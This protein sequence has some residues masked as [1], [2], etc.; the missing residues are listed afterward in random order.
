[1]NQLFRV[2]LLLLFATVAL[3]LSNAVTAQ[4]LPFDLPVPYNTVARYDSSV[5]TPEE[6]IGHR[7]GSRHTTPSQVVAYFRA[8]ANASDRVVLEVHGQTYE[9]RPLIHA[10]ITSADNHRRLDAIRRDNLRLVEDPSGVSDEQLQNMP[11]VFY[12]GYSIHGNEATGTEAAVLFLYHLAAGRDSELDDALNNTVIL[13]DPMF[14][15]DGRDR[16]VD[17]VNRWRGAVATTDPQ[18]LEHNEPWPGGRTNHYFFDLNRDWLPAQQQES[19][20]R[21]ELF[22]QWKPQLLTDHHEMGGNSTFFFQPGVPSRT[23][24]NTPAINQQLTE[25]IGTYHAAALDSYGAL[26]YSK[27]SFDDFYYGK[28]STYPDINGSIGILFEQA[29]S[30]ALQTETNNGVLTYAFGVRNHFA[31]SLS[32]LQA[33]QDMRVALLKNQ[34]DFYRSETKF[35]DDQPIDGYVI[36]TAAAPHRAAVLLDIFRRHRIQAYVL[37]SHF[38][39]G[40]EKFEAGDAVYVPLKQTQGRLAKAILETSRTFTDSLF[41][42]VSTW[43]LPLAMDLRYAE[44]PKRKAPSVG[45]QVVPEDVRKATSGV[46]GRARYAYLIQ[47]GPYDLPAM[48]YRL[49]DKGV[50]LQLMTEPVTVQADGHRVDLDRGAVVVPV[51]QLDVPVDSVHAMVRRLADKYAIKVM[52]V[53]TGATLDGP[54]LGSGSAR[55]IARPEVAIVAGSRQSS[56]MVGEAWQLLSERLRMPVSLLDVDG[57]SSDNLS[58][59][60]VIV[61][62]GSGADGKPIAEWVRSGGTLITMGSGTGWAMDNGLA[63]LKRRPFQM[64]SVLAG[65]SYADLGD[66]RGAQSLGGSIVRGDVDNTHP[67]AYGVGTVLPLFQQGTVVYDAPEEPGAAVV[68]VSDHP[69]WS[70]YFSPLHRELLPGTMAIASFRSGR[71]SVITFAGDPNFRQFWY[72]TS[73]LFVNAVFLGSTL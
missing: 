27:Q 15:P 51:A 1:M 23:N 12:A 10:V 70:G 52:S 69:E 5:P 47:W 57:L 7:I 56:S 67:V 68:T 55:Q 9:G 59:Y 34:R 43:T 24:P 11:A 18:D 39:A 60:N 42:D 16:F 29:S 73:R 45:K 21:L 46:N 37:A 3:S 72:G 40:N 19:R 22:H 31:A 71:G 48:L 44:V 63:G 33:L 13:L 28:G 4:S 14:N 25:Q 65:V 54:F 62:A 8:V 17:W 64:D 20:G 32:S 53:E 2:V 41:Y 50:R 35:A 38:E 6:V 66:T 58:R 36:E 26:Y 61:V 49:L 30:R